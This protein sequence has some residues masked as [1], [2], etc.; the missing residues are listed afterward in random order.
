MN[1]NPL[2]ESGLPTTDHARTEPGSFTC[3]CGSDLERNERYDAYY[4]IA[5]NAWV[6]ETCTEGT[7]YCCQDRPERP[8][9]VR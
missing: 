5:G 1:D 8:S 9:D 4:C 6:E 7:C 2:T 3:V